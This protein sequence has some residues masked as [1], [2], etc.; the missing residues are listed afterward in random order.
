MLLACFVLDHN[1]HQST[2]YSLTIRG[3]LGWPAP[4]L[5]LPLVINRQSNVE[6]IT[7]TIT[8]ESAFGLYIDL[9]VE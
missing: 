5:V 9:H 7:S 3:G 6:L 4:I 2:G 8:M 1:H